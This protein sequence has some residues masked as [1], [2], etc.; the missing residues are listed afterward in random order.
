VYRHV[1]PPTPPPGTKGEFLTAS[2][3]AINAAG[4][5]G[6][7]GP[8]GL[9]LRV[10]ML[11]VSPFSRGGFVCSET[12]D[13]TS[14]LRFL[15]TRFGAE[16]PNLSPWRRA[17]SGDLTGAFNFAAPP[18]YS[19]PSLAPP[20]S[21]TCDTF[22]VPPVTPG[23]LPSQEPGRRLHPSGLLKPRRVVKR[24]GTRRAS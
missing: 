13:H 11:V 7:R 23:A 3:P 21:A 15:E 9:G 14:T 5:Q 19:V 18:Q 4:A 8:I 1:P 20:G 17:H 16:V 2:L 10:G 24:R 12:F 6:L 22:A